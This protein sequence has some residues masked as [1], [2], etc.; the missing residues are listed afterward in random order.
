MEQHSAFDNFELH[1]N[2]SSKAFL[3]ETAK[4][5]NFLAIVGYVFLGLIVIMALFMGTALASLSAA[6]GIGG[7]VITIIYL[8]IAALYFFPIYFLQRFAA[9]MKNAFDHNDNEALTEGFNF[10]KKH[11][12]F[13]GI[14]MIVMI[15]FYVLIFFV[16]LVG[17][18]AAM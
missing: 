10:L 8:A 11:Y 2:E 7:G 16:A 12:K 9:N 14:L 1:L 15:S 4:W 17:G 13:I 6:G 5:A 3:R 18:L